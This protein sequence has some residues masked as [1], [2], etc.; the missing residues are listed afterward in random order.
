MEKI[1]D[2]IEDMGC[3]YHTGP[4]PVV[5][6]ASIFLSRAILSHWL[7]AQGAVSLG[8]LPSS[9]GCRHVN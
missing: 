2:K 4:S 8:A 1:C 6:R 5:N 7:K 9:G 3:L